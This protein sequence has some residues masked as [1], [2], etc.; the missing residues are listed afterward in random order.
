MAPTNR[1]SDA[2]LIFGNTGMV[3]RSLLVSPLV[4]IPPAGSDY[5]F[6]TVG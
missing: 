4:C 1:K 5:C 6:I 3:T 2:L